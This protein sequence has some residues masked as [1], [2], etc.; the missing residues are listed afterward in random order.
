M[1]GSGVRLVL[2]AVALTL[3]CVSGSGRL[4]GT[5]ITPEELLRG[6]VLGVTAD[7]GSVPTE[8]E[9]LGLSP[10]MHAFLAAHVDRDGGDEL[11]VRQLSRAI[12]D[13]ETFGL[14]YEETTRTAA[15][16]F[17]TRRGNCLSFSTMFIAMARAAGL[18]AQYQVVDVPPEWSLDRETFVLNRHINVRVERQP[19]G[20]LVVDFN[21]VDFRVSYDLH[22]LTDGQA[23]AQYYNNVGVERMQKGDTAGA[24]ASFRKAIA[25]SDRRFSPA[26][27]NLGTLYLR[28]SQ[29]AYAEAAFLE[30]RRVDRGNLVAMSNLAHLYD[31]LGETGRAAA[32][33]RK[34]ARHRWHNPYY[35]YQLARRAFEG[36]DFA[37][38]IRHLRIAISQ[39]RNEDRFYSLLGLS[40]REEGNEQAARHW[41]QRAREVAA[42]HGLKVTNPG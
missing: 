2:L 21:M 41:L 5:R 29:P 42:S 18:R 32:Y 40:Y 26:W 25:D 11:K 16:T 12:F 22:V 19:V 36:K 8:A 39:K 1:R 20:A 38:A 3:G 7:P 13:K 6:D 27:T 9:V 30:A 28:H 31:H 14:R 34:V 37:A 4:A 23:L 17:R 24:L 15:E 35:H 10:E 33:R